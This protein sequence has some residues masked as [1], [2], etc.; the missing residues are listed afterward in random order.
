MLA[1]MA[2]A[3]KPRSG[4]SRKAPRKAPQQSRSQD[5]VDVLLQATQQ[6]L[7]EHGIEGT[8][9]TLIARV[10]GVGVGTLYQ[11]YPTK[12]ALLAAWEERQWQVI[13]D[14]GI[15]GAKA[16]DPNRIEEVATVFVEKLLGRMMWMFSLYKLPPGELMVVARAKEKLELADRFAAF[17]E[18]LFIANAGR[19]RPFDTRVGALLFV[20]TAINMTMV[21]AT[22]HPD[23]AKSGVLAHELARMLVR[24]LVPPSNSA[25]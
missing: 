25:G 14:E 5:T 12:E 19:L 1:V 8:T 22:E 24:Y 21:G 16:L 7:T 18:S 3:R 9:T 2:T 13:F 4:D 17:L 23:L 20:K 15:A 11:Y 10:A 6:V